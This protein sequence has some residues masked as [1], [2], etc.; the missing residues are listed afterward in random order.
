MFG[1]AAE[2]YRVLGVVEALVFAAGI[3]ALLPLLLGVP[4]PS[5]PPP[6]EHALAAACLATLLC[7]AL[8]QCV[9]PATTTI[10]PDG[11]KLA[12]GT[13]APTE[14]ARE[15][16]KLAACLTAFLVA[17]RSSADPR[18][19]LAL[20]GPVV[21]AAVV[22]CL[23]GLLRF[24]YPVAIPALYEHR[25]W[26]YG[27]R[28]T[29]TYTNP[30]HF[31]GMLEMVLPL[32]LA[33]SVIAAGSSPAAPAPGGSLRSRLTA[34][35]RSPASIVAAAAAVLFAVALTFTRSRF[36]IVCGA[37]GVVAF[38]LLQRRAFRGA[39]ILGGLA[40][41]VVACLALLREAPLSA[42]FDSLDRDVALRLGV[43]KDTARGIA[44]RYGVV[45][46]GLGTFLFTFPEYQTSFPHA[47]FAEAHND[48]LQLVWE[49]GVLGAVPAALF[50]WFVLRC[51]VRRTAEEDGEARA[52]RAGAGAAVAALV[53]HSLGDFNLQVAANGLLFAICAGL[54]TGAGFA[55]RESRQAGFAS[56]EPRG[57][58]R[59]G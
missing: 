44:G 46:S 22:L 50:L 9:L 40:I 49:A 38:V 17:G 39:L 56:R 34:I 21:A 48:F 10:P 1:G 7:V 37:G 4:S 2:S 19:L 26:N 11:I 20:A 15:T 28:L 25:V 42:R 59:S 47:E 24:L 5:E 23:H 31:A 6:R 36:G 27:D 12:I 8:F 45:G 18:T 43:W 32:A 52:L 53:G 35:G 41:L 29:A 54:A 57:I 16:L 33:G 55:S 51:I 58:R 3:V 14:T 30:N 13:L